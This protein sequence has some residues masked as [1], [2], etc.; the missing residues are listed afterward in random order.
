MPLRQ[1]TE[2]APVFA[3]LYEQ[4]LVTPSLLVERAQSALRAENAPLAREFIAE[5]S[6]ERSAPLLQW[7]QLLE[8]PRQSLG[9]LAMAPT[10]PVEPAALAAGFTRLSNTNAAAAL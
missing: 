5:V 8:A 2:C 3:W 4:K 7:L 10:A 1:P 6:P 9:L